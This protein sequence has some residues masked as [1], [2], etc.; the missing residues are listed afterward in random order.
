MATTS[1]SRAKMNSVQSHSLAGDILE[2][3]IIGQDLSVLKPV[4]KVEYLKN[5]CDSLGMNPLTKPFEVMK[6]NG[7]E[8]PYVRKDGTEQ[9][10]QI[11]KVSVRELDSQILQDG[12]YIVTAY[13][14]TPD[15]RTDS[16]TGVVSIAGL[17]GEALANAMMKA[18]TKAKRRVTLSICGL[19]F[20]D[21]SE[22]DSL[23]TLGA[24]KID[25]YQGEAPKMIKAEIIEPISED[26]MNDIMLDI[27]QCNTLD[28]LETTFKD[29]YKQIV[30]KK[31]QNAL[32][33]LI[34]AKDK[35]KDE[36]KTK[37]VNDIDAVDPETG[38]I[39]S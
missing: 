15:G 14:A 36:I 11:R 33:R 6:F 1:I 34:K 26:D 28:E 18:E 38:E 30:E 22:A 19:G 23:Y 8:I 5:L 27:S 25:V 24:K 10:R 2:K 20:M 12:I 16:A 21:E 32:K 31:D 13:A 9:L 7:K 3:V 17:K 39:L 37:L 35:R 29:Y 4:E